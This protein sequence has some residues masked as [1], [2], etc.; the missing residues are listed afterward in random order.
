MKRVLSVMFASIVVSAAVY[1]DA[2]LKAIN[3]WVHQAGTELEP[4]DL[5]NFF[6][7][8]WHPWELFG[9]PQCFGYYPEREGSL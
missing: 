3:G 8:D 6:L 1:F 7:S 2:P 5:M 4:S 9:L